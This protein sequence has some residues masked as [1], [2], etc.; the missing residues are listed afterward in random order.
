[1]L[2]ASCARHV[3]APRAVQER[4]ASMTLAAIPD[5]PVSGALGGRGFVLRTAW[6]RVVR[7]VGQER[8]DLVLSEGRPSRLCMRPTPGDA[9]QVV[10]RFTGVTS[11]AP[12]ELRVEP[13]DRAREVFAE[14]PEGHGA[15]GRGGGAA[16]VSL[17]RAD[18]ARVEGRLRACVPLPQGG[19][20][21]G[22]F[23]AAVC[24]D[25]LD[26]DGPR[27]ARDRAGDGG[28]R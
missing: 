26:L 19:C 12:G 18:D 11:L 7:R 20:V 28:A 21:S 2:T 16:L 15:S 14:S 6:L 24:W 5:A 1:M 3:E 9:R 23:S 17:D 22:T 13:E 27:G 4:A 25:E 8:L 10:L